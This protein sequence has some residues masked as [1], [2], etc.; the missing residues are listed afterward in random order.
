[1]DECYRSVRLPFNELDI[2]ELKEN[3]LAIKEEWSLVQM[4][5]YLRSWSASG[6]Y[7]KALGKDPLENISEKLDTAWGVQSEYRTTNWTLTLRLTKKL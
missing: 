3:P 6:Y 2:G 7:L 4:K 5:G 1:M